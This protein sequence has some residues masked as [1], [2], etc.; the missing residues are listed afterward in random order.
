MQARSETPI[1]TV[2]TIREITT[3][4]NVTRKE[5]P[6]GTAYSLQTVVISKSIASK[7]AYPFLIQEFSM[8]IYKPKS[9]NLVY[10][11]VT[12]QAPYMATGKEPDQED[13][14]Q[15]VGGADWKKGITK[16]N[17]FIKSL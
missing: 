14:P 4:Q 16:G 15:C 3:Y 10:Q 5:D 17:A 13:V 7:C 9:G 8:V 1:T 6:K 11:N 12:P 2:A